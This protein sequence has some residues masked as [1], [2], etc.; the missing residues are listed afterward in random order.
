[1]DGCDDFSICLDT[2]PGEQEELACTSFPPCPKDGKCPVGLVGAVCNNEI[3]PQKGRMCLTGLCQD[4][5]NCPTQFKCITPDGSNL[6]MCSNGTMGMPCK[7]K[8]DCQDNLGCLTGPGMPIG[9]CIPGFEED[10]CESSGGVCID[11]MDECPDGTEIGTKQCSNM[12]QL[13]CL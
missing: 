6:G 13:C 7:D 4:I 8:T 2:D 12:M 3:I 10:D 1:M 11:P 9:F 5:N